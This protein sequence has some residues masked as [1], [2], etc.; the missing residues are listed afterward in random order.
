MRHTP[1]RHSIKARTPLSVQSAIRQFSKQRR[2]QRRLCAIIFTL[3]STAVVARRTNEPASQPSS[4]ISCQGT[5]EYNKLLVRSFSHSPRLFARSVDGFHFAALSIEA[6]TPC[7]RCLPNHPL[8]NSHPPTPKPS[9]P[10]CSCYPVL[11]ILPDIPNERASERTNV[12]ECTAAVLGG[13]A[14][15]VRPAACATDRTKFI[16]P[17]DSDVSR[18]IHYR[19]VL[20]LP[21]SPN[22]ATACL[23]WYKSPSFIH[24]AACVKHYTQPSAVASTV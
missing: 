24:P 10:S 8:S 5:A 3:H 20:S 2:L 7:R 21:S 4:Q 17:N 18:T 13:G 22:P 11:L 23:P 16:L 15:P 14:A 9:R 1:H 12:H 6:A 19:L